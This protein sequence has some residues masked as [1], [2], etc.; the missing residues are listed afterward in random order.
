MEHSMIIFSVVNSK[1]ALYSLLTWHQR[2]NQ[3][4]VVLLKRLSEGAVPTRLGLDCSFQSQSVWIIPLF[5]LNLSIDFGANT[6]IL[7]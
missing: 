2:K 7:M 4:A 5:L 1:V 6:G 3:C